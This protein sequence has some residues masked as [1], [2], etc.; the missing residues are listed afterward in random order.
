[1]PKQD[2][3]AGQ[4]WQKGQAKWDRQNRTGKAGQEEKDRTNKRG[5]TE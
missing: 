1:M 5:Q 2:C 3:W 4:L